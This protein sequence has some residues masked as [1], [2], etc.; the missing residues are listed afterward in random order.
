ML[1]LESVEAL[2]PGYQYPPNATSQ[3]EERLWSQYLKCTATAATSI[4]FNSLQ[5]TTVVQWQL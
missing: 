1:V 2:Q 5:F 4:L 3:H